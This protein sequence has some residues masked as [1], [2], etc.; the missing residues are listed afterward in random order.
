M[1]FKVFR[2]A[3][4]NDHIRTDAWKP[5]KYPG[6]KGEKIQTR[7]GSLRSLQKAR[8]ER[9]AKFHGRIDILAEA[10]PAKLPRKTREWG[11][12]AW[13]G[14]QVYEEP[15][16]GAA[17]SSLGLSTPVQ[18]APSLYY[19]LKEAGIASDELGLY[20]QRQSNL[21]P[22]TGAKSW[23]RG[24]WTSVPHVRNLPFWNSRL[25]VVT[26]YIVRQRGYSEEKVETQ[27][28]PGRADL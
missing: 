5:M 18:G 25:I 23:G 2:T 24:N 13:Q 20:D 22:F 14:L 9:T 15:A 1:F 21:F 12:E 3:A 10:G 6:K 19:P 26:G 16:S 17:A 4:S 11:R 8:K 27:D 7:K 28:L